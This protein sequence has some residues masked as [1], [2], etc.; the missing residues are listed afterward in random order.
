MGKKKSYILQLYVLNFSFDL[1]LL[2]NQ[3]VGSSMCHVLLAAP[4][5]EQKRIKSEAIISE[6]LIRK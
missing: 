1:L 5:G 3:K 4:G 2:P 6:L